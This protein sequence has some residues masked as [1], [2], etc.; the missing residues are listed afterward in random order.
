MIRF[1][2]A[3]GLIVPLM[4]VAV[5]DVVVQCMLQNVSYAGSLLADC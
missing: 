4:T 2:V 5:V 1:N 3:S